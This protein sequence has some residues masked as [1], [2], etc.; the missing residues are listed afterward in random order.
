MLQ[1]YKEIFQDFSL[2]SR[3]WVYASN[4]ALNST[5]STFVQ[6]EINEFV[7]QWATHGKELIAKGAVLFDRFIILAVDEQKVGASGC[8][9]DSSVHFVKALGKELEV[10]FFDRL[11][12]YIIK[13]QEIKQI[14]ISEMANFAEWNLFD[15]MIANLE[16]LLNSWI[17][18]VNESVLFP[19]EQG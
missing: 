18:P 12:L 15:P 13:D 11:N 9:I 10:N 5:E 19:Q 14:H 17:V 16:Q 3:V 4:R 1:N 6:D 2:S 8:S 7:K